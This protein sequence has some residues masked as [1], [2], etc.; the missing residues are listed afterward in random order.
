MSRK[1]LHKKFIAKTTNDAAN[2]DELSINKENGILSRS[3]RKNILTSN[4][5][6]GLEF[7]VPIMA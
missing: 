7:K 6:V 5:A 2:N 3:L 4:S 1:L